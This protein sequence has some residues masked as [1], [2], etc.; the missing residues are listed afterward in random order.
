MALTLRP[1]HALSSSAF[2][3]PL[4]SCSDK[5]LR[6]QSCTC[7][8]LWQ[9]PFSMT[10]Q[11]RDYSTLLAELEVGIVTRLSFWWEPGKSGLARPS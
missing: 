3:S 9:W 7:P 8:S 6:A 5:S 11:G 10:S 2:G 1:V 4:L